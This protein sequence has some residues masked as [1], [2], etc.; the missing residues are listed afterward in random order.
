MGIAKKC[1]IALGPIALSIALTARF[2]R[3]RTKSSSLLLAA[4]EKIR[5]WFRKCQ[6]AYFHFFKVMNVRVDQHN[7]FLGPCNSSLMNVQSLPS[8]RGHL[9]LYTKL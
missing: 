8:Y 3:L 4:L 5:R 1:P 7:T 2:M 9:L 6:V